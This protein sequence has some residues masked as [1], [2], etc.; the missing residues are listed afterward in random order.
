MHSG[1]SLHNAQRCSKSERLCKGRNTSGLRFFVHIFR[2]FN[3]VWFY[4]VALEKCTPV[5]KKKKKTQLSAYYSLCGRI[6]LFCFFSYCAKLRFSQRCSRVTHMSCTLLK[7]KHFFRRK[8][9]RV[10][11]GFFFSEESRKNQNRC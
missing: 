5:F 10:F 11:L 4:G 3:K 6:V 9:F 1:C 7:P 2:R 8:D